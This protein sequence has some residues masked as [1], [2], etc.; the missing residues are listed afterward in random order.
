MIT[1][2]QIN[3]YASTNGIGDSTDI[4]SILSQMQLEYKTI[5][6]IMEKP[7]LNASKVEYSTQDV[8]D[9]FST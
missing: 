2:S 9:L 5:S 1:L 3:Q 7:I 8:L 4:F 6:P